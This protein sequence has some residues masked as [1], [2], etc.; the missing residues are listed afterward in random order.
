[1]PLWLYGYLFCSCLFA[2][3]HG[4]KTIKNRRSPLFPRMKPSQA[5][6]V[7]WLEIAA[8]AIILVFVICGIAL[9]VTYG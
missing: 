8:N 6:L 9:H 7:G 3:W 4:G 1:M 5:V 2:L